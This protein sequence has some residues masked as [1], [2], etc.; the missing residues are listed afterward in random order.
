LRL[1]LIFWQ[2]AGVV[3]SW[4]GRFGPT[5]ISLWILRR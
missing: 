3:P 2:K 1:Q 4:Y 5:V